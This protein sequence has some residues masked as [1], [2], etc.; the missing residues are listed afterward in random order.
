MVTRAK[1]LLII[2]GDID[3]LNHDKNWKEMIDFCTENNAVVTTQRKLQ[4]RIQ[5]P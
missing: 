5:F 1:C 2:I 4:P 3:T